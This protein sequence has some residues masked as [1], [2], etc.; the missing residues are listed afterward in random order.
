[1][2]KYKKAPVLF[3]GHG[4]PMVA[5]EDSPARAGM[6]NMG[7]RLDPPRAIL[8]M[9]AHWMTEGLKIRTAADNPKIDDMY[10]FP[11][12]LY[13]VRYNPP[14]DPALAEKILRHLGGEAEVDNS[15]GMDH[16]AWTVL[17]NMFPEADVPVIMMSTPINY[18]P[19]KMISL[20]RRLRKFVDQG[21]MFLASGNVVHNLNLVKRRMA[22]KGEDW[23]VEF[24]TYIKNAVVKGDEAKLLAANDHP[25]F[26]KAVY[27]TDHFW[28][29]YT[30]FGA[31]TGRPV[32]VWNHSFDMGALSM[33]SYLFK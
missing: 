15:W 4:S 33:T 22:G 9:S 8:V 28:P 20:G 31:G 1:M 27:T 6:W 11:M 16:G 18:P 10:G 13:E 24:D 2:E 17:C 29:L 7:K 12:A 21:V 30:A 25:D 26:L 23:A 3:V 19:A 32:K 5:I 14:A